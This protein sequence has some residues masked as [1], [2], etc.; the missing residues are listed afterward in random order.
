MADESETDPSGRRQNSVA[1][2]KSIEILY[3]GEEAKNCDVCVT[4]VRRACG[5]WERKGVGVSNNFSAEGCSM[6]DVF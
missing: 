5:G 6:Q 3:N 4:D 2:L 1:G